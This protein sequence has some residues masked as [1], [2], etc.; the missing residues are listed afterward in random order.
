MSVYKRKKFAKTPG[1]MYSGEEL[2]CWFWKFLPFI[3]IV[4]FILDIVSWGLDVQ[5]LTVFA[6]KKFG[7]SK[8]IGWRLF[9]SG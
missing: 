5:S 8:L 9:Q 6:L 2:H 7:N 4:S 1:I 3:Y